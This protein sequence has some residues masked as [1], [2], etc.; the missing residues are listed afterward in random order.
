MDDINSTERD[1][2]VFMNRRFEEMLE[3]GRKTTGR[4]RF[5][6]DRPPLARSDGTHR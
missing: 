1:L 4:I 6:A 5:F 2:Q 3:H